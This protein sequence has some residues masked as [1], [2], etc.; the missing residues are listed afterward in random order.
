MVNK[1]RSKAA[2][3][4]WKTR[5]KLY[6]TQGMKRPEYIDIHDPVF[7]VRISRKRKKDSWVPFFG[8]P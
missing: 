1:K 8:S 5:K 4:A 7:G 2:K 6:G 3:K